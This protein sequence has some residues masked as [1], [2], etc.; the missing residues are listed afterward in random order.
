[1]LQYISHGDSSRQNIL[2]LKKY[3]KENAIDYAVKFSKI[4]EMIKSIFDMIS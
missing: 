4:L 1:M 2:I 3:A